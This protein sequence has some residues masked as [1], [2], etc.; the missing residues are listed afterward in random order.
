[1][2][3]HCTETP[4]PLQSAWETGPVGIGLGGIEFVEIDRHSHAGLRKQLGDQAERQ[5]DHRREISVNGIDQV[6][7]LSLD[8]IRTGLAETFSRREVTFI[9]SFIERL[10]SNDGRGQRDDVYLTS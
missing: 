3:R 7:A 2:G 6:A 9:H 1:M 10:N 4:T 5:A 8:R